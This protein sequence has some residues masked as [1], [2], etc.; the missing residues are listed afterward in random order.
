MASKYVKHHERCRS[1]HA[2]SSTCPGCDPS[3]W[4]D[5]D[6]YRYVDGKSYPS[7]EVCKVCGKLIKTCNGVSCYEKDVK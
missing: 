4:L 2:G 7:S 6:P 5:D 3:C 1:F